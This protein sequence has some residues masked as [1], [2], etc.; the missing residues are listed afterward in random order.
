MPF[1]YWSV[2][3]H[4]DND[5]GS[6][7]EKIDIPKIFNANTIRPRTHFHFEELTDI[8]DVFDAKNL[9]PKTQLCSG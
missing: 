6:D 4:I 5:T 8:P 1:I 2:N 9:E 7:S 3:H